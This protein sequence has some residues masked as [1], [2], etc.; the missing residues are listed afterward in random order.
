[1]SKGWLILKIEGHSRENRLSDL[2]KNIYGS[3]FRFHFVFLHKQNRSRGNL[4]TW[5]SLSL[6]F[7]RNL[8]MEGQGKSARVGSMARVCLVEQSR[9]EI[10][11]TRNR[12]RAGRKKDGDGSVNAVL[13]QENLVK[14]RS[15]SP[16]VQS[17]THTR[18]TWNIWCLGDGGT[19]ILTHWQFASML[20]GIELERTNCLEQLV[21]NTKGARKE[22]TLSGI[23]SSAMPGIVAQ[24]HL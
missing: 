15:G 21:P 13:W 2:R 17:E 12:W 10:W 19:M 14:N 16:C 18:R 1:M 3:S 24:N 8:L 7:S 23:V 11:R 9:N 5:W 4:F 20:I 6:F 22:D